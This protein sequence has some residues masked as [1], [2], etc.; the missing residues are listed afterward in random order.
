MTILFRVDCMLPLAA[1]LHCT[2]LF[3]ICLAMIISL[4]TACTGHSRLAVLAF[5]WSTHTHTHTVVLLAI[6]LTQWRGNKICRVLLHHCTEYTSKWLAEGASEIDRS[7]Y[8]SELYFKCPK[9]FLLCVRLIGFRFANSK[10][11]EYLLNSDKYDVWLLV[12]G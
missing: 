11:V 4:C 1:L 6:V 7:A 10:Y 9:M 12:Y 8:E 2:A 5:G 3:P